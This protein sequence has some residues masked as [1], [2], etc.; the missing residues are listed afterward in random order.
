M[1]AAC[2]LLSANLK[3]NGTLIIR[4]YGDR[5]VKMLV[6]QCGSDLPIR[7]TAKLS[8]ATADTL[9]YDMS[10]V[11][12]VN[13]SGHGRCV[14]TLDSANKKLGQQLYQGIVQIN[15]HDGPIESVAQM[16]EQ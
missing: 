12:L 6:V 15:D 10:F 2:A 3:F 11:E 9:G 7:A 5:P 1:M 14:I 8:D 4:I 16:L 13:A